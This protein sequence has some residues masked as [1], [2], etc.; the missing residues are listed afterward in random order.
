MAELLMGALAIDG[1]PLAGCL[2]D[3]EGPIKHTQR[4]AFLRDVGLGDLVVE[5]PAHMPS[6]VRSDDLIPSQGRRVDYLSPT[7]RDRNIAARLLSHSCPACHTRLEDAWDWQRQ[8][9][10]TVQRVSDH[11][12]TFT[13][14]SGLLNFWGQRGGEVAVHDC[15]RPAAQPVDETLTEAVA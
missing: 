8:S 13:L 9:V 15:P 11:S 7:A 14:R 12:G 10:R 2:V 3:G 1:I 6:S 4:M 5:I